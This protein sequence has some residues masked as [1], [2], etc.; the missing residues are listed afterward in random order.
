MKNAVSA[1]GILVIHGAEDV[2][3]VGTLRRP[4]L[5]RSTSPRGQMGKLEL[6]RDRR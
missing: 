2:K 4:L 5:T 6:S 3:L 1:V